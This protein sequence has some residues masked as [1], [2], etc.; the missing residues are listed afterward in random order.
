MA[1]RSEHSR[2]QLKAMILETAEE[3]VREQGFSALKVRKIAADIGYTV[4]SIYMV[5]TNM[6]DLMM[7]IKV[8]TLRKL[9][10]DLQAYVSLMSPQVGVLKLAL[11]YLNFIVENPALWK[12]LF[13][14]QL[15]INTVTPENYRKEWQAIEAC[16]YMSLL[17]CHGMT[18]EQEAQQMSRVLIKSLQGFGMQLL[19]GMPS[20][21]LINETQAEV[22]LLVTALLHERA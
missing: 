14:H 2:E 11:V 20:E 6:D 7:H 4:A 21:N 13:E 19:W 22:R 12:M 9:C 8:R 5:F 17:Q 3:I 1:R 16:F 15:P 18:S 10:Q